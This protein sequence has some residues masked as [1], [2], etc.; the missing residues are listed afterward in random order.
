[1]DAFIV[2]DMQVG[3]CDGPPKHDLAGVV[4]RINVLS[5][6][7]RADGGQVIWI[8]HCGRQGDGFE[9][10]TRGFEF[11][12]DLVRGEEDEGQTANHSRKH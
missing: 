3:L 11:L 12:P 7:V 4:A 8:R 1:M 5:G 10:G 2:V 9:R 6:K